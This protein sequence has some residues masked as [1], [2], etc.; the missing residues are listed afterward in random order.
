MGRSISVTLVPLSKVAT[1]VAVDAGRSPT[2]V[3]AMSRIVGDTDETPG[4]P[5]TSSSVTGELAGL[6]AGWSST[7]T[8][9]PGDVWLID[10]SSPGPMSARCGSRST[11]CSGPLTTVAESVRSRTTSDPARTRTT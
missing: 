9:R 2:V 10:H 5:A 1:L 11:G 8:L 7:V 3:A 6:P 4:G